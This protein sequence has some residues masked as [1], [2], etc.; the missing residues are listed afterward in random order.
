MP[1]KYIYH[2]APSRTEGSAKDIHR[3]GAKGAHLAEMSR[4]KLCVP[5]GFTLSVK[6]C[7][8]FFEEGE[9]LAEEVKESIREAIG[10][11]EQTTGKQFGGGESNQ[12]SNNQSNQQ[13]IKQARRNQQS[14]H[15]EAKQGN[16]QQKNQ[17]KN[18][19]GDQLD[20]PPLLVSV[21]SGASVS[22][23]GM[24][25]SIL[26][27]GWGEHTAAALTRL[28]GDER[29]VW[30]SF[31]R[32][33]Q[34]YSSV[35][36]K[37]NFSLFEVYLQDYKHKKNYSYDSQIQAEEWKSIVAH[38][39][40]SILQDT[41]QLF[42]E[43]PWEQLWQS[44]SAV[45][46]SWNNPRAMAYR[47][48]NGLAGAEG[49]AVNI[50]TMVYGNRGEDCATGVVFT[51]NPST[52]EK[53]LFGEFLPNA[54]GED[55]VSG[56]RTPLLIL[57]TKKDGKKDLKSFMPLAFQQLSKLCSQLEKHYK[58]AQDIEFTIEKN[59]LW[60]LQTR[61]AKCSLKARLKIL[62]DLKE[63]GLIQE[64]DI[65]K[66]VAPSSL[67]SFLHPSI[68]PSKKNILLAR[69]LP[70][71]PGGGIGRIAFD[72]KTAEDL[73]KKAESVVL[74]RAETS[75]D[76][77]NGMLYSKGIL[78]ARGG[79]TSHAAVVARSMGKPCVVGCESAN[80]DEHKKEVHF[81]DRVLKEG[82]FISLDGSSGE[83]FL[84][85]AQTLPPS[86]DKN[87]FRLMEL[88]DR[89]SS[90]KIRANAETPEDVKKAKEFGAKGL[91]LCRTEH[92]FFAPDRI[93]IMRKM[94][95]SENLE[96]RQ[97]ALKELFDMQKKDFY[98][99]LEIMSPY[100]VTVR[101]LDPPLH[102][103]LP[104]G[105][106]DISRLADKIHQP[107][108]KLALKIKK[109]AESNPMLGHR[110]CRLAI[111][112]PEI[113]LMQ[114]QALS[115]AAL[116]LIQKGREVRPELMIPLVSSLEEF[117]LLKDLIEKEIQSEAES[118]GLKLSISVGSMIELPRAC[119][120]A[121]DLARTGDFFSFGTND[122]TQTVF[123]F[124]RDD[125]AKFLPTYLQ[126]KILPLD[127]FVSI[128]KEGVGELMKIAVDRGRQA[129][130]GIKIG[131]CGEQGA[132]PESLE[133][134]Q[135]LGLDYVSCSPYRIPIARLASAQAHL[136]HQ[137]EG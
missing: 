7:R 69:G 56:I 24:M 120:V 60:L 110:G 117:S 78:T 73:A 6:L 135:Q 28:C 75:P 19:K 97:Q 34:M 55:V 79:M 9:T 51:R 17:Q 41:G 20:P 36:M 29:F 82:E 66:G 42:P 16:K 72:S 91:G 109:L 27:L 129:Q 122:L 88:S 87:L 64:E 18:Q 21:R 30:D 25:D 32:F 112:F 124:S 83:V 3:L 104:Q 114:V 103:F 108:A 115:R 118:F 119:L 96:E 137:K 134:F 127:P 58:F 67:N 102:E 92:M 26:N 86:M 85:K 43:D 2:F 123:G 94:I 74:V 31:R 65:L 44:I 5:P 77:I 136:S 15:Q 12:Q 33:I 131:V 53:N 4:L 46:K 90:M 63:E 80:I 98:E 52:G 106:E 14:N 22:M 23:P 89:Y 45:F 57:N 59:Q 8:Q 107:S 70:A 76:D 35:V 47:K 130:K 113:Y 99:I 125:S 54:Q 133:F 37:M 1:E 95:L 116:E 105:L 61:N 40:E 68:A 121:G 11:L 81:G 38:F 13:G 128:D 49:T 126:K 101:L 93:P 50:Q 71:S 84:G 132:D 62:F 10:Q 100:P 111:S 48:M 39:K